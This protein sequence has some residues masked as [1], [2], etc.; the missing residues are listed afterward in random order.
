MALTL[1]QYQID[2]I[3]KIRALMASG[4]KKILVVSPT[5]CVAG[6]TLIRMNRSTSSTYRTIADEYDAQKSTKRKPHVF[7]K[8]RA[9]S[10]LKLSVN[11]QTVHQGVVYSG[12]KQCIT[13]TSKTRSL[14]LTPDHRVWTDRGWEKAKNMVGKLWGVD[15]PYKG[16]EPPRGTIVWEKV[17]SIYKAGYINTYDVVGSETESF[18]ANDIVVHNSG[19]TALT[20]KM[21]QTASSRGHRSW[22]NVHRRE[23]LKQSSIA[24]TKE[25]VDHSIVSSGFPQDDKPLVQI[26]SIQTLMRR[27]K[28]M[29]DPSLIV[30]DE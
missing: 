19:K 11:L 28:T 12:V 21:L 2:I 6:D 9:L 4:E 24:F 10:V 7:S 20:T 18:T 23:L 13:L 14:T 25:N 17:A 3:D 26:N 30:V 15:T 16:G 27:N 22:F 5:G 29:A 1:R 8:I